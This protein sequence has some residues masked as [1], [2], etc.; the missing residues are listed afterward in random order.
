MLFHTYRYLQHCYA[1]MHASSKQG[2][3]SKSNPVQAMPVQ[4]VEK[5][6]VEKRPSNHVDK[7]KLAKAEAQRLVKVHYNRLYGTLE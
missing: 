3:V 5:A 6:K 7:E 2:D 1:L 4:S